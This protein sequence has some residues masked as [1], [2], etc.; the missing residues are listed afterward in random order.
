MRVCVRAR[1][2]VCVCVCGVYVCMRACVCV[3]VFMCVCVCVRACVR[4]RACVCVRA[5][6]RMCC[7]TPTQPTILDQGVKIIFG[8]TA[9]MPT[10]EG[11]ET[12][13]QPLNG[14]IGK[15]T[16]PTKGCA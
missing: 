7:Y 14:D 4:A 2:R 12:S 8:L 16:W 5:R 1:A 6:A 10:T 15:K 9:D 11:A 3:C 13:K